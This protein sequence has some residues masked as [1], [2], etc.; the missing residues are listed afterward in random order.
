MYLYETHLHT[1]PV[2]RCASASVR[3]SV[4]FYKNIGYAGI[5]ITNHFVDGN[6]NIDPS[7]PYAER[8]EFYVSA[9][10]EALRVGKEIGI[11]V[12]F[13]VEAS[14][15]GTD[16]LIYGLDAAW[17][18]AHPEIE[19][20]ERSAQLAFLAEQGALII[21][22]HPF[23]EAGYIDHIRLFPR[24]VHGVEIYNACRSDFENT[25]AALYAENYGLPIFAGTDNHIAAR[26]RKLG[27]MASEE[28]IK[29]EAHF[30]ELFRNSALRPFRLDF[31]AEGSAEP[32]IL[33]QIGK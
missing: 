15:L 25:M 18:L 19:S 32:V 24:L 2:S 29:D 21:H 7:L 28:P 23:R 12:F 10:E 31:D 8:I 20:M 14:Y 27:G 4:E 17:Y 30:I 5:F 13:G 9:Y 6:I 22:A 26:Q 33:P 1:A 3:E 11:D 16:F